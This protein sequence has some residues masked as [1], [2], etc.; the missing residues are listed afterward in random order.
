M[1][2]LWFVNVL[3]S[4]VSEHLGLPPVSGPGSW[5]ENLRCALQAHTDIELGICAPCEKPFEPI[6]IENTT[7][8][9]LRKTRPLSAIGRLVER[10]RIDV[11]NAPP[12]DE[13]L[14]VI[15]S[16]SPEVI[17]VHGTEN[18]FGLLCA[19]TDVP[20][21]VS[22]QGLL[23]VCSRFYFSGVR[24]S[25]RMRLLFSRSFPNGSGEIHGFLRMLKKA[26]RERKIIG[27]SR[28]LIGRTLWDRTIAW[29]LNPEAVYFH[30]AEIIRPRFYQAAWHSSE[31]DPNCLYCTSSAM[32][33][34]G[35]ETLIEAMSILRS[36]GLKTLRL[37]MAGIPH[38]GDVW[39]L[40]KTRIHRFGLSKAIELLGRIDADE[41]VRQIQG[42]AIFV[43]PSH[44]DN[45]PNSLVE[46]MLLGA[47]I[48]AANSGGIP[49]LV[50]DE[51][52]G[53][54]YDGKDPFALA[55]RIGQLLD[56]PERAHRL[57]AR[58]RQR[59]LDRNG[60]VTVARQMASIYAHIGW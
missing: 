48:V 12:V 51:R 39:R 47:P 30:C 25:E 41:I 13:C 17:H 10:W 40:C 35:A 18:V 28:W 20:V 22:M 7:Y 24:P 43:Y 36:G 9:G 45:S 4:A 6:R 52:E 2:I 60:P 27:A 14:S 42:A 19:A 29:H 46:A 32:L 5:I 44:V 33:F 31:A 58:A 50:Q 23:T 49:S 37:K 55:G 3:P 38:D 56:D 1:K 59:A 15:E 21:V 26:A 34:K 54:L 57:G 11:R 16:F 8:Y 53:L